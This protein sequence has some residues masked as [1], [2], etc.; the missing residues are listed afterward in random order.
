MQNERKNEERT[1]NEPPELCCTYVFQNHCRLLH[2]ADVLFVTR[3]LLRRHSK[4][5]SLKM[6]LLKSALCFLA[7]Q[8]CAAFLSTN[9]AARSKCVL[10]MN[11]NEEPVTGKMQVTPS[12]KAAVTT[13][14]VFGL[15]FGKKGIDGPGKNRIVDFVSS[16]DRNF[17][18]ST[19]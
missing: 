11:S 8:S 3:D 15:I 9:A 2:N 18:H 5:I 4:A 1:W 13:A 7:L 10:K 6:A 12:I 19:E 14:S 16:E 17:T